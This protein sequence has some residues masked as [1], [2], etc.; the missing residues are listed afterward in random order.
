M[1]SP[2]TSATGAPVPPVISSE[3]DDGRRPHQRDLLEVGAR[4]SGGTS[5]HRLQLARDVA[6]GDVVA[7]RAR[8]ASGEAVVGQEADVAGDGLGPDPGAAD[9]A[10][11]LK[12]LRVHGRSGGPGGGAWRRPGSGR[13]GGG[14]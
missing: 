2:R 8:V 11:S 12:P 7:V 1:F 4:L 9:L 5:S 10:A 13:G 6:R 14:R 3:A